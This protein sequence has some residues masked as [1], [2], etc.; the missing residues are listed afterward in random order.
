MIAELRYD[1]DEPHEKEALEQALKGSE[2]VM[3]LQAWDEDLR[4]ASK[5]G[6]SE[7]AARVR[8]DLR[9]VLEDAGLLELVFE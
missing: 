7:F 5:H 2:L 4:T 1:L 3:C 8:E 6:G 9:A